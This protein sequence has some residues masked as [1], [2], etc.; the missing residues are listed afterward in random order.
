MSVFHRIRYLI[1]SF[2]L[3]AASHKLKVAL[4]VSR[5]SLKSQDSAKEWFASARKIF[6]K[7]ISI[8][9][10]PISMFCL[11]MRFASIRHNYQ[12]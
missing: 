8:F 1:W 2:A 12:G 6:Y 9:E 11:S 4:G 10:L 3:F 5:I 7:C